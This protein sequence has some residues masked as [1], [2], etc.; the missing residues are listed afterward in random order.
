MLTKKKKTNSTRSL[1]EKSRLTAYAPYLPLD[2]SEIDTQANQ[3][4]DLIELRFE[5]LAH[6]LLE[7]ESYEVVVDEIERTLDLLRNLRENKKYFKLRIGAV[8]TFLPRNQPLYAF[9][10][11]V[12]VPSFMASEA[13][14]RIPHNMKRF[15]PK[16][17]ALLE[18]N[19]RCPNITVSHGQRLDFLRD[20][21]ALRINLK[22]EETLPV[23]EAVI[24]TGTPDHAEQL[25]MSFDQRTL[26]ITN[27]SGH[28]PIV[29][30]KDANVSNA[31]K[32][33]LTLQLYNQGQDCAA[34]NAVLVHEKI[35]SEFLRI[36]R[37]EIRL[38][39]VGDYRDRRCRVGPISE[40]KDLVRIQDF[41]IDNREWLDPTTPGIVRAY[42]AIL[43]PTIITKPLKLGGNFNEIFAPAFFVQK[44]DKDSDLALYFED[45]HYAKNAMYVT[46]YGNSPYVGSLI[47]RSVEG[48]I[49]HEKRSFLKDT[50]LHA[51][52]SER[53][54]QP[55]GGNGYGASNL[56]VNGQV[57]PKATLP[58]RDIYEC[59]AK[60]LLRKG[61]LAE[62]LV[63][64][65]NATGV[66]YK[67]VQKMMRLK[68]RNPGQSEKIDLAGTIY[69]D[70]GG[71]KNNGRRYIKLEQDHTIHLLDRPNAE[72]IK[73]I[74][75]TDIKQIRA[76]RNLILASRS[77]QPEDFATAV[78]ALAANARASKI[79]NRKR[80]LQFFKNV[81]QLL[82]GKESGPRLAQFLLEV[83][84][85]K[86]C[87]LLDI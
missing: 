14:F 59:V 8:A 69:I 77:M 22:T 28:N 15:F 68:S 1:R 41:L 34:P 38:V 70:F 49:L 31:V 67:D 66:I 7:Y 12:L 65:K 62:R 76:L 63:T 72:Y 27:G 36:L 42:D 17:L 46:L 21:T 56:S 78:Y 40:P 82:F 23:T 26:F 47:G 48:K 19:K 11:F 75:P 74:N 13:H 71:I 61:A 86:V 44:Y 5:E 35:F 83:D 55:Y 20:R 43:E 10:C 51:H 25:R 53:G 60:P 81:Y 85:N 2:F 58:Q 50:H 45:S 16:L 80:Q 87:T 54:T 57:I 29:V 24:F 6:I 39:R 37:D 32:A 3:L 33:T 18:I 52:G 64:L 79:E 30:S 84:Q 73:K 4:A 9:A